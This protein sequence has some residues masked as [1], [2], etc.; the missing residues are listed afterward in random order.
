MAL[1]SERMSNPPKSKRHGLWRALRKR[2][3]GAIHI[4]ILAMLVWGASHVEQVGQ[5]GPDDLSKLVIGG[6]AIAYVPLALFRVAEGAYD[7]NVMG[8]RARGAAAFALC[9]LLSFLTMI[10]AARIVL[11]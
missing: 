3:P 6:A 1:R 11:M 4:V 2:S 7:I 10:L 5:I 8:L 9:W